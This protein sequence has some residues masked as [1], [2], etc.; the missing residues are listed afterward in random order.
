[1]REIINLI[2]KLESE[3]ALSKPEWIYLLD[4]LDEETRAYMYERSAA[5]RQRYYGNKVFIRALIE[6]SNCCKNDCLYCGIRKSN[7]GAQRYRLSKETVLS[8][9][10]TAYELGF[11]TFVIQGGESCG[12]PDEEIG[13]TIR[14]IKSDFPDCAVTLSL[15]EYTRDVYEY[16]FY[17]GA[18]R[19][20]LR[21]ETAN[22]EHYKKLHPPGMSLEKRIRCLYDLK[23]IGY[24]V[25][26]GI[27]VGSPYQTTECIADDMVF[28]SKLQPHMVGLGPFIPHKDTPFA[29]FPAGTLTRTLDL[30]SLTRLMLP[31]VL[32]PATTALGTISDDGRQR[33]MTVG[34]N[35][36]MPNVSPTDVR[37]KYMLYDNKKSFGGES[38]QNLD[39]IKHSM[40][41]YGFE[42]VTSR[43]DPATI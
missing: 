7:N 25:G 33:G 13:N 40:R 14:A 11:R 36:C 30:L 38:A 20:L 23:E 8:C 29:S 43:G 31:N 17:C 12:I 28:M 15:G 24:L 18:D 5:V 27:M 4:N 9:C 3:H 19:Y 42:V 37:K 21:H 34:A 41:E 32:L 16:W 6:I 10:R 22:E 1:M 2:N 39:E 35:V 26:C